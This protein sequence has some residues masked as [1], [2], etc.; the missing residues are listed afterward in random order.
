MMATSVPTIALA[1]D[2]QVPR[3]IKGGWQLAGGHGA[4]DHASAIAD[5][6]AFADAGITAFDCAD[7]YTGVEELIGRFL[8]EYRNARGSDASPIRVHTKCVP[9]LS[10]LPTLTFRDIEAL[11]DRSLRRLGVERLDLVQFHWWDYTIPG[12]VDAAL[13][14]SALKRAGKIHHIGITNFDTAHVRAMLNAGVPL[15]AHQM[16]V[17]LLDRRALGDMDALCAAHGIGILAYGALA[18][19]FLHERWLGQPE[20]LELENRSLVKY[21]LIIDDAGGWMR[22]QSLLATLSTIAQAHQTT[23]GAVAL[24]HVLHDTPVSAA[25]VGARNAAHLSPTLAACALHLSAD[26]TSRINEVLLTATGPRGDV[27]ALERERG[28]KHASIMRY[29]LNTTVASS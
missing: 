12:A 19:G 22:F 21:K 17:S 1:P 5:M 26:E 24:A 28:G 23:I 10:A 20:P 27:Y 14:L 6:F 8:R 2:Y 15:R 25:I 11:I 29:N 18:G 9:D 13:H 7:I 16:Q 3:L 4:V